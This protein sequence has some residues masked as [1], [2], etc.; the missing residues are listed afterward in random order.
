MKLEV[1]LQ[2]GM[3]ALRFKHQNGKRWIFDCVRKK[4]LVLQPE[5]LVRQLVI[6]Y[7]IR[8][9]GYRL[10]HLQVERRLAGHFAEKRCD[11]LAF[12]PDMKPFL[13][14]ECKAPSV[15]IGDEGFRQISSYNLSL[16]VPYFVLTN[17]VATYCCALAYEPARWNFV[18]QIP[19]H[20]GAENR[21]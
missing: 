6:Q 18:G 12:S 21:G 20:P 1:D 16:K 10:S 11:L 15:P 3:D 14:V 4:W 2:A 9:K 7:L 13:L 8:E 19:S 5:E 17:G